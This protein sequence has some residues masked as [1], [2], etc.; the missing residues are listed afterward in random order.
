[1]TKA[2]A[3]KAASVQQKRKL[4]IVKTNNKSGVGTLYFS[5]TE[6]NLVIGYMKTVCIECNVI[7]MK[8]LQFRGTGLRA[9]N[10]L[11]QCKKITYKKV[12][13]VSSLPRRVQCLFL[14]SLILYNKHLS[15]KLLWRIHGFNSYNKTN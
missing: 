5:T 13:T 10:D 2:T 1:M 9:R 15:R 6:R 12:A 3:Q 14:Y 4:I 7:L 11:E 8:W